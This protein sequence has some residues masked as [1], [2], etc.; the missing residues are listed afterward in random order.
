M[1]YLK[2]CSGCHGVIFSYKKQKP[3]SLDFYGNIT[4]F[5]GRN[6][7]WDSNIQLLDNVWHQ[8][9][10]T[11]SKS[12]KRITLYVIR[13]DNRDIPEVFTIEQ[14]TQPNPFVNGGDLSMGR[15][16]V[17]QDIKKWKKADSFVGCYDSLGF[18]SR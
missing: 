12:A 13:E 3:F 17:S 16:Q 7:K 4:I 10:L 11:Y 6:S 1:F 8:I 18:A 14:F 9:V 2:T 5:Y 15:F